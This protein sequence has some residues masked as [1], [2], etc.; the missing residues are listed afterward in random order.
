MLGP[1][2]Q[3]LIQRY[4]CKYLVSEAQAVRIAADALPFV[5]PDPFARGR[6]Q[7]GYP[8]SSLYLDDE[9]LSLY[10]E[11]IDGKRNRYK[12]RVRAYDD[13]PESPLFCEVKRRFDRVISKLRCAIAREQLGAVLAGDAT[14]PG[15]PP[16]RPQALAEFVRLLQ[17]TRAAPRALVRYD[18]QAFVG[19]DDSEVR[20]TFDRRLRI[21]HTRE[22]LVRMGG[23][24][25]CDMPTRGVVLE[26]K[27][28]D[29]HPSWLADLV[30][31]H[32]LHRQSFS[33]YCRGLETG[34]STGTLAI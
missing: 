17:A 31:R 12:L 24:G 25:F 19:I 6:P 4:E 11:T 1:S 28:C 10:R 8:I 3:P 32:E 15:P 2:V 21:C 29:R 33:K 14:P 9:W 23:P 13:R 20:V 7:H 26:L 22:P 34:D 5:E 27:Y 30:R 18:R 16:S